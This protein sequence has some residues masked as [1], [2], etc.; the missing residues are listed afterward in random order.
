[1]DAGGEASAKRSEAVLSAHLERAADIVPGAVGTVDADQAV[2][3]ERWSIR[4]HPRAQCRKD[5]WTK[6]QILFQAIMKKVECG[7]W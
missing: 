5:A 2:D 4:G 1:M 7:A 3:A 6:D